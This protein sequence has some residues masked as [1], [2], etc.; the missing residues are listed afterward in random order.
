MS[1]DLV[2]ATIEFYNAVTGDMFGAVQTEGLPYLCETSTL[3]QILGGLVHHMYT[4][5][6]NQQLMR[7]KVTEDMAN[8][9]SKAVRLHLVVI[10]IYKLRNSWW[11]TS[12]TV[13][14]RNEHT[15]LESEFRCSVWMLMILTPVTS[16]TD[17]YLWA[18]HDIRDLS[19][20]ILQWQANALRSEIRGVE[21]DWKTPNDIRSKQWCV[22]QIQNETSRSREEVENFITSWIED[23]SALVQELRSLIEKNPEDNYFE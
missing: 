13:R 7:L 18:N 1:E 21:Q 11:K 16:L 2:G 20:C 8:N 12:F 6:D 15:R 17:A 10:E 23:N 4:V 19:I 22:Q 14:S 9:S 5:P 3:R